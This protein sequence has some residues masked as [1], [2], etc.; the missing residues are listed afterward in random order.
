M[1]GMVSHCLVVPFS[2]E[3]GLVWTPAEEQELLREGAVV[4]VLAPRGAAWEL[5]CDGL[6]TPEA[7]N[8]WLPRAFAA[9]T[10]LM[11][12]LRGAIN[13]NW[14]ISTALPVRDPGSFVLP[15]RTH[16]VGAGESYVIPAGA[17]P[18][19]MTAND[20]SV[21]RSV[22]A[23]RVGTCLKRGLAAP[24]ANESFLN[25][26]VRTAVAL[27]AQAFG[28]RE[29]TVALLLRAMVFEALAPPRE[30]HPVAAAFLQ[31]M[32]ERIQAEMSAHEEEG[33]AKEAL[34]S[35]LR[36]LVF[37]RDTSIRS[38]LFSYVL[39]TLADR[40]DA[41][42]WARKVRD[43][44]DARSKLLHDGHLAPETVAVASEALFEAAALVLHRRLGIT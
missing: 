34:E 3:P 16:L 11:L 43:A 19:I 33:E 27:H 15:G 4:V 24:A 7:A 18:A 1:G 39:E 35:L 44:Y 13:A 40:A 29:N 41:L 30:K 22:Q 10:L 26:R 8:L 31:V 32:A 17:A 23:D 20:V 25:E 12:D 2:V 36:E 42:Q 9:L 6:P 38:R 14:N 28:Q 5:R 21:T 37:R